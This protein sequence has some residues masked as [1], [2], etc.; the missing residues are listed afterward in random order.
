MRHLPKRIRQDIQ[1]RAQAER[2][3]GGSIEICSILPTVS[4][5]LSDGGE[6]FFQEHDATRI[7]SEVPPNVTPEDYL[8]ASAQSW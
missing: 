8:L 5:E 3:A 1:R 4:I 2:E 6:Y 7:L